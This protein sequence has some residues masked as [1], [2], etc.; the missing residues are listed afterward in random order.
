MKTTTHASERARIAAS[1]HI[2]AIL[3]QVTPKFDLRFAMD[4]RRILIANL[5]K[6]IIGVQASNLL[7]SLLVSDL[8]LTAM[9]RSSIP[10]HERVPLFV[11]IDAFQS[12]GTEAFASI[13]SEARKFA[14]H[15]C[16]GNQYTDALVPAVR[17]AVLG[18]AGAL[19]VFRVGA[20][21]AELLAPEF[22]PLPASKLADQAPYRA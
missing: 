4:E 5:G 19:V 2:R 10:T 1:P 12:F 15:F 14:T 20:S 9:A 6:G 11:H 13:L 22:H 18:N 17:A 7:G 21:D 16:V 8:H 3:G